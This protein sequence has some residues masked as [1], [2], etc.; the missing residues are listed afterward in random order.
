MSR[1]RAILLTLL[2]GALAAFGVTGIVQAQGAS[3]MAWV[4]A[5]FFGACA[6]VPLAFVFRARVPE[7]DAAGVLTIPV[8][9]GHCLTMAL[10]GL[11]LTGAGAAGWFALSG[12]D[13]WRGYVLLALPAPGVWLTLAYLRWVLS[14]DPAFR[15]DAAG[16]TRFQWG[17]RSTAWRDITG[18]GQ[19]SNNGAGGVT[20]TLTAERQSER[21]WWSRL[22]SMLGGGDVFV[23]PSPAGIDPDALEAAVRA[24]WTRHGAG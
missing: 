5:L 3:P 4:A 6:I 24:Y 14:G 20:L 10:A 23:S 15:L 19:W 17:E 8:S 18:I 7:P 12:I 2:G 22:N 21:S 13:D 11:A 1:T 9:R 16:L